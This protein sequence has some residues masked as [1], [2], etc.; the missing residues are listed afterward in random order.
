[1]REPQPIS[2]NERERDKW[3]SYCYF[4][5]S[6]TISQIPSPSVLYFYISML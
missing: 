5:L 6:S 2:A 1:M 4:S 3:G